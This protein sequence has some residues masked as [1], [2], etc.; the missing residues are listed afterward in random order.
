MCTINI[1]RVTEDGGKAT[2][3]DLPLHKCMLSLDTRIVP[4]TSGDQDHL[5]GCQ[6]GHATHQVDRVF[7]VPGNRPGHQW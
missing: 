2:V 6:G 7:C 3:T 1:D 4:G 5:G